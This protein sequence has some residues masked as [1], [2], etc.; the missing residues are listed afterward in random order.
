MSKQ[1]RQEKQA[2]RDIKLMEDVLSGRAQI[3]YYEAKKRPSQSNR[4]G[5]AA[6]RRRTSKP[7]R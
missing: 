6:R 1:K 4:K 3:V 2:E 5:G 7:K